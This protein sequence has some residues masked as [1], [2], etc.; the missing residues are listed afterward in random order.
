M[1]A[2]QSSIG[3][4]VPH[5]VDHD[6]LGAERLQ[7]PHGVLAHGHDLGV[8]A[9]VAQ[10]R[11][12][13]HPP[14]GAE[15]PQRPRPRGVR[16]RQRRQVARLGADDGVEREGQVPGRPGHRALGRQQR[17]A[18]RPGTPARD[19]AEGRLQSGEPVHRRRDAD[20]PTAVGPGGQR[21][22][23]GGQG[24]PR[25]AGRPAGGAVERP[26]VAGRTERLVDRVGLP[27]QLRA[28]GLA[29]DHAPGR[30]QPLDQRRVVGGRRRPGEDGRPVG[31][32][33]AGRVLEVLDPE[34]DPGQGPDVL[35]RR[36]ALVDRVRVGQGRLGVHRHEGAHLAVEPVDA[37]EGGLGHLAGRH[38]PCAHLLGDLGHAHAPE[39]HVRHGTDQAAG[40]S[41]NAGAPG[42][43][44]ASGRLPR[45]GG[46]RLPV[47]TS[48]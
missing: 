19:P 11:R 6:D 32:D 8:G 30:P 26:R 47:L 15:V 16:Q 24:R 7:P 48:T 45:S 21:D 23:A 27:P 4:S 13:R 37:V 31:G 40:R 12:P 38:D 2:S 33:E 1:S 10:R 5:R 43:V 44:D 17:P 35:A 34:R 3:S 39:V 20:R 42:R 22:Q 18:G 25:P 14:G 28:V 29:D 36:D 46:W 41:G 9:P